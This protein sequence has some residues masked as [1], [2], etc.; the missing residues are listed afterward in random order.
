MSGNSIPGLNH[1]FHED[2]NLPA[3]EEHRAPRDA[4][5]I[6]RV[7]DLVQSVLQKHEIA[8]PESCS[9]ERGTLPF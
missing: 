5:F 7:F 4:G 6:E 1:P 2:E 3:G 8:G 9:K